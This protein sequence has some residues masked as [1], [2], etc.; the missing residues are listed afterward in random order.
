MGKAKRCVSRVRSYLGP[1][2][3][4]PQDGRPR[5]AAGRRRT[6]IVVPSEAH[7]LILEQT[8]SGYKPR[9]NITL[10]DDK[11]YPYIKVTIHEPF[12]RVFVTRRVVNDA[13]AISARTPTWARCG[14]ALNVVKRI[15]TVRSC[16]YA[17]R[18]R[19]RSAVPRLLH[20]AVQSAVRPPANAG[21]V[22]T[23]IDEVVLSSRAD[24]TK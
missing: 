12:P 14:G 24:P 3:G 8:S 11:S 23:M 4:T 22:R 16:N 13:R 5:K 15:F 7:A 2:S 1:D 17:S 20:H 9:F 6:T 21:R 18:R 10:R 19:C